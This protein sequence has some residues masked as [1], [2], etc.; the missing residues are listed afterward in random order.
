MGKNIG[1]DLAEGK[2]TLPLIYTIR[3]GNTEQSRLI[4]AAIENDGRDNIE[5][6]IEAINATGAIEYTARM[7]Q[8]EA[9]KAM[10]A[11]ANIAPSPYKDALYALAEFSVN[12]NH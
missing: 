2:P 11:I 1:D 5:A 3:H 9:G 10:S 7:A 12:R 4:R 8:A 6:V